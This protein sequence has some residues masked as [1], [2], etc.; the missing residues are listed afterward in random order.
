MP[1][2]LFPTD[3]WRKHVEFDSFTPRHAAVPRERANACL[4]DCKL[5]VLRIELSRSL[6]FNDRQVLS[7]REVADLELEPSTSPTANLHVRPSTRRTSRPTSP[8]LESRCAT[9]GRL[10]EVD[11]IRSS[12]V[13]PSVWPI[14]V[15]PGDEQRQLSVKGISAAGDHDLPRALVLHREN[16]PFDDGDTAVLTHGTESLADTLSAAPLSETS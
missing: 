5:R 1:I 11:F 8:R 4:G 16:K 7:T 2:G 14:P 6:Q 12:A 3:N 9:R 15:V 13:Q 10:P